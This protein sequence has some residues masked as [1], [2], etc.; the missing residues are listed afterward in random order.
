M[1][2]MI[3]ALES[4][5]RVEKMPRR[6]CLENTRQSI[7]KPFRFRRDFLL[8]IPLLILGASATLYADV[9][10][11]WL[12]GGPKWN[13]AGAAK[14]LVGLAVVIA[15]EAFVYKITVKLSLEKAIAASSVSN[16]VSAL[17]GIPAE[18]LLPFT[19]MVPRAGPGIRSL[20]VAFVVSVIFEYPIVQGF[21][22]KE[23]QFK[24]MKAVV[25]A[26]VASYGALLLASYAMLR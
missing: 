20:V 15:I 8:M 14:L 2:R 11:P 22:Q 21:F 6:E 13:S 25:I 12:M 23:N 16:L 7:S 19:G 10:L 26:N 5:A 18:S 4:T 17:L 1:R 9:A 24:V 3:A